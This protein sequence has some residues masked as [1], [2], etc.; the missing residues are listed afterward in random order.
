VRTS[1]EL[2]RTVTSPTV[3]SRRT[4]ARPFSTSET[5]V[6]V[7]PMSNVSRLWKPDCRPIQIAP[8]T[9]PAGPL[10]SRLTG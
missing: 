4:S 8:A 7:P 5:S 6:D 2:A 10:I 3:V 9:P 1:I